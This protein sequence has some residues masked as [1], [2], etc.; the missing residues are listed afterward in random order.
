MTVRVTMRVILLVS[1]VTFGGVLGCGEG[2]GPSQAAGFSILSGADSGRA[3]VG[4]E[5]RVAFRAT[6]EAGQPQRGIPVAFVV[7]EGAGHVF[8]GNGLTNA[9]GEMREVWT[10]GST[11][12]RQ[13]L[14]ARTVDATTGEPRVLGRLEL[15]TTPGAPVAAARADT[16]LAILGTTYDL[17]DAVSWFDQFGNGWFDSTFTVLEVPAGV[18]REGYQVSATR[19]VGGEVVVR[20]DTLTARLPFGFITDLRQGTW[21][22]RVTC[23]TPGE[24]RGPVVYAGTLSEITYLTPLPRDSRR[25]GEA[26]NT[27]RR[28]G[29]TL[30][31]TMSFD[32]TQMPFGY[33]TLVRSLAYYPTQGPGFIDVEPPSSVPE[34][35]AP[36]PVGRIDT[37]SVPGGGWSGRYVMPA[38]TG[39]SAF[40]NELRR[41]LPSGTPA[42]FGTSEVEVS[43]VR[44]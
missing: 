30:R 34:G 22:M 44:Q 31:G 11:P 4:G 8:A 10:L 38:G 1:L 2:S 37:T 18:A 14:E 43:L 17:R 28:F 41:A 20:L 15:Q 3:R 29:F 27:W 19:E 35:T 21:T 26:E 42:P 5:V 13:A 12:G 39:E 36:A 9:N 32:G 23:T 16:T 6:D 7:T 25:G 33:S 24:P 40:C